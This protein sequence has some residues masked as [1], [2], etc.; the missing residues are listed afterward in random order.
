MADNKIPEVTVTLGE[1]DAA[2]HRSGQS[3]PV[4]AKVLGVIRN[5][6][7]EVQHVVLDRIVHKPGENKFVGWNVHG[8][9]ATELTR[10]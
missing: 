10:I 5:A 4:I 3:M 1:T 2:F 9:V 8:A 7:G 6:K